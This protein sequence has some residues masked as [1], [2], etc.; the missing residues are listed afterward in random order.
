[1]ARGILFLRIGLSRLL[2]TGTLTVARMSVAQIAVLKVAVAFPMFVF[3]LGACMLSFR[4]RSMR[5]LLWTCVRTGSR[6][7]GSFG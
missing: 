4:I 2:L 7:V 1:M 6:S 5:V 3:G